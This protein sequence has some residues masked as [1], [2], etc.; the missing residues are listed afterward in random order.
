MAR[1]DLHFRLRIPAELKALVEQAAQRRGVSMTAEI[2]ER[3]KKSFDI[4]VPLPRDLADRIRAYAARQGSS[5]DDEVIR[6]LEREFP[7][8]WH[9]DGRLEELGKMLDILSAGRSDP[10]LDEFVTKFEETVKGIITGRVMGV[11]AATR[12]AVTDLWRSYK[13]REE[14]AAFEEEVDEQSELPEEELRVL[15]LTG[16]TEK[17]AVPPPKLP[18]PMRDNFQLM[19]ILPRGPLSEIAEKLAKGDTEAAAEILRRIPKSEIEK[20]IEYHHS[21][22][23]DQDRM[24]ERDAEGFSSNYD[25]FKFP[26]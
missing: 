15:E 14:E 12:E 23:F 26:E 11:D 21:T 2:V 5:M 1:E 16:S 3:L 13:S 17:F 24:R 22:L 19:D 4:A 20:R 10:R 7:P 9:V 25:P 18:N 8:Q 6:L